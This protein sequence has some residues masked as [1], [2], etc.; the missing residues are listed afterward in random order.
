M[1]SRSTRELL[2]ILW[3]LRRGDQLGSRRDAR[4]LLGFLH[5]RSSHKL[6]PLN[7][8]RNIL[9][10]S[11]RA[12][13]LFFPSFAPFLCSSSCFFFFFFS[14]PTPR[15]LRLCVPGDVNPKHL[16][17]SSHSNKAVIRTSC[18]LIQASLK[19]QKPP[20]NTGGVCGDG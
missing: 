4:R 12:F 18:Q 5:L 16:A 10:P 14:P 3:R 13:L 15:S 2:A 9:P 17:V 11:I 19:L 20:Q 6:Y 7:L 1:L 8:C